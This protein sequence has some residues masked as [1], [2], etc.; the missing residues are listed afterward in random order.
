ME[1]QKRTIFNKAWFYHLLLSGMVT[2]YTFIIGQWAVNRFMSFN[3]TLWD[4]GIM[5]QAIWNTAHGS[6]L[7]ESVNLGFSISRLAVAHWELIYLPLAVIYRIIPSIP[8][9]LYT[10][11]FILA[12]GVIPIYKFAEKKLSSKKGASFIAMAYLFYPALHGSN[13]FDI[14]GL[15]FSTTFLLFTFYYLDQENLSKTIIFAILSICCREDVAFVIFMLGLY[16]WIIK[17]NRKIGIILLSL[18]IAWII[19]FFTRAYFTGHTE[20]MKIISIAP[21][22]EHLGVNHTVDFL[23]SPF[24]KIMIIIKF[25][26]SYENI[27]YIVKLFL[28][29]IGLC[30]LSPDLLFIV[31]PI[32]LSNMLSNWQQMHQIE[33]HY[34]ATITPF[35]FLAAIK[36]MATLKQSLSRFP[37]F[38]TNR[39]P[40][41]LGLIV[42]ISSVIST[43][44]FS[45]LRFHKTWQV[46]E[47]H[48][49]LA[50]KLQDIP[51]EL[52]VSTTARA[53]AHLANRKELYHFA[54]PKKLRILR[55]SGQ[56]AF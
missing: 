22:W 3:A 46:S 30:C 14:H 20:L 25:L 6:I 12:C 16:S 8:L 13:L 48:K 47:S 32:L 34:T 19:A 29:V 1:L 51:S 35:I 37:K 4:M 55:Y 10:Q 26:F 36:G 24:P 15:T 33:Y 17:K 43:T 28:P 11:S 44:Q 42:V 40:L 45:I 5:T 27:K 52:S 31:A 39:I 50:Q 41:I 9:L 2:A 7:H 54:S 21:N 38:Q 49:K 53:G 23:R 18:S 56:N